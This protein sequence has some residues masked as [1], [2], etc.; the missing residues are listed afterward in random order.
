MTFKDTWKVLKD[1]SEMSAVAKLSLLQLAII[2]VLG[3]FLYNA[4]SRRISSLDSRDKELDRIRA[5]YNEIIL[6]CENDKLAIT[7]KFLVKLDDLYDLHR[8]EMNKVRDAINE[9]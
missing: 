2:I 8:N 6:R 9:N 4:E 7:N 1:W 3:F 5:S